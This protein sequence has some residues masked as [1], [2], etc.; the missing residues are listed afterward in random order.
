MKKVTII[1]GGIAGLSAG[2]ALRQR[3]VPIT[4]IESKEYPR[5][6][7]CGEFVSG[8]GLEVLSSIG[9][10]MSAVFLNLPPF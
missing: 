2:I 4:V 1:G 10:D 3:G 6:K 9:I 8:R 5:H 7:V